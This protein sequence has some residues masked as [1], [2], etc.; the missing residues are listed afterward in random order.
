MDASLPSARDV[1]SR[2]S[3]VRR[4]VEDAHDAVSR[5]IERFSAVDCRTVHAQRIVADIGDVM[6]REVVPAI[7]AVECVC[8]I[9]RAGLPLAVGV[10]RHCEHASIVAVRARRGP[11]GVQVGRIDSIGGRSV[12]LVDTIAATGS[13]AVHVLDALAAADPGLAITAMF[14]YASPEAI[15]RIT[16]HRSPILGELWIGH[17]ADTVDAHGYL[18][19]YTNGDA[20]DKL[21]GDWFVDGAR[22]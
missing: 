1:A 7:R 14:A 2:G 5:L 4:L 21:Y 9:L 16:A 17:M 3:P 12:L 15:A 20:G 19:P 10:S 11:S 8:P 6:G 18:V 22:P 13:T